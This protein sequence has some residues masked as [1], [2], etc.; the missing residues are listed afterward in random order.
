MNKLIISFV[1]ITL[2]LYGCSIPR[3]KK[4]YAEESKK[5][6]ECR[7]RWSYSPIEN[8]LELEILYFT[9][10]THTTFKSHPNFVIGVT[11][12][13]DTIGIINFSSENDW[14]K[15]NKVKVIK[16][17]QLQRNLQLSSMNSKPIFYVSKSRKENKL[18][19]AITNIYFGKLIEIIGN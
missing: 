10:I 8:E 4:I 3:G 19:C 18:Q 17:I 1:F 2:F 9:G 7:A 5:I 6:K 14:T 13:N 16:D 11:S 12:Q 15:G